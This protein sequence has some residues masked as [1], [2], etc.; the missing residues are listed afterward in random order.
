VSLAE[1]LGVPVQARYSTPGQ[2]FVINLDR[3][4]EGIT[5]EFIIATTAESGTTQSSGVQTL[6]NTQIR[7]PSMQREHEGEER[8][9]VEEEATIGW[10]NDRDMSP[11]RTSR[12]P[13]DEEDLYG[14]SMHLDEDEEVPPTQQERYQ[15]IFD[16]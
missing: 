1:N 6:W 13:Q 16:I 15:G 11:A 2:P 9:M 7:H 5:C 14:E 3:K 8:M 4:G 10:G 12:V